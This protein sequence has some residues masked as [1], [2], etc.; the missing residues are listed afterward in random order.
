V[1]P[2]NHATTTSKG[3]VSGVGETTI[4]RCPSWLGII[5]PVSV[6][7]GVTM[8]E[9]RKLLMGSIIGMTLKMSTLNFDFF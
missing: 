2:L 3:R 5:D 7:L 6:C 4:P 9:R 1:P 8:S